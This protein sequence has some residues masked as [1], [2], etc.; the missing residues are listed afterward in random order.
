[1][2]PLSEWP[3]DSVAAGGVLCGG[4]HADPGTDGGVDRTTESATHAAHGATSGELVAENEA[5]CEQCHPT[6][7]YT[8]TGANGHG[9]GWTAADLDSGKVSCHNQGAEAS[10]NWDSATQLECNDCHYYEASVSG[11][12]NNAAHAASLSYAHN[13]H[14]D[15]NKQCSVCHTVEPDGDTSHI[16]GTTLVDRSNAAFGEATVGGSQ[17]ITYSN[18]N[19]GRILP[20]RVRA[21]TLTRR[22]FL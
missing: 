8:Q 12:G 20:S 3:N 10:N 21:A 9:D 5:V 11:S 18:P 17:G 19:C 13:A 15:K 2:S 1:M 7:D 16:S 4:C 6:R 22:P 14:F